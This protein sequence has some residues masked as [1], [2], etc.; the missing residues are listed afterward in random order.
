MA[1]T[2]EVFYSYAHEDERLRN[3][4]EQQLAL[5]QRYEQITNW[6]DRKISPGRE[7]SNEIDTNLNKAQI[8]L[9]LVSPAFLSSDY[10]YGVEMKRALEKHERGEALVIPIIL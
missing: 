4:L 10:C 6:H 2:I 7:W 1:S 5:L 9:L 3:K 8:I